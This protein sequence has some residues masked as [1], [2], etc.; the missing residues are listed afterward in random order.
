[1]ILSMQTKTIEILLQEKD[2]FRDQIK[3]MEIMMN[4]IVEKNRTAGNKLEIQLTPE[5]KLDGGYTQRATKTSAFQDLGTST[6]DLPLHQ[7]I[8]VKE[9]VD[10]H[11]AAKELT[12]F[13]YSSKPNELVKTG[14]KSKLDS[15]SD[16]AQLLIRAGHRNN[17][18]FDDDIDDLNKSYSADSIDAYNEDK[19]EI[20]VVQNNNDDADDNEDDV[21]IY[22]DFRSLEKP[23][24][25][26]VNANSLRKELEQMKIDIPQKSM[27]Y[28][29]VKALK[30]FEQIKNG[31]HKQSIPGP[32]F[33]RDLVI[34]DDGNMYKKFLL[35]DNSNKKG[36]EDDAINYDGLMSRDFTDEEEFEDNQTLSGNI[37]LRYQD[38]GNSD[39]DNFL[40][41]KS[42]QNKSRLT[43][44]GQ[45][46][47]QNKQ[48]NRADT[49]ISIL[50][51]KMQAV[52]LLAN[53]KSMKIDKTKVIKKK[54]K[55]KKLVKKMSMGRKVP[56]VDSG[57]TAIKLSNKGSRKLLKKESTSTFN[58]D[59]YG[60]DWKN[61]FVN[62]DKDD[63][64]Q[65]GMRKDRSK[66]TLGASSNK[67]W[68]DKMDRPS[69]VRRL[70]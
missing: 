68:S 10:L 14:A 64:G 54:G 42:G 21:L 5:I 1:M 8:G 28:D 43:D 22:E 55:K 49:D 26:L 52:D 33:N 34:Q 15:A 16:N 56:K 63:S 44:N 19:E 27:N 69:L 37:D 29:V 38:H 62:R 59:V 58:N 48:R 67:G 41:I 24:Q 46:Y 30:N 53:N 57:L 45:Y 70:C 66:L 32:D 4:Q 11:K 7:F 60:D 35:Q 65:N 31:L 20:Q 12:S 18:S 13:K 25:G 39:Y 9:P 3:E 47:T 23:Q 51:A 36:K 17:D 50:S 61:L 40:E 6:R 2:Y